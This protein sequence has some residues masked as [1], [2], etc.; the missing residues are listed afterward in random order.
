M[1]LSN[2][3]FTCTS[4][5]LICMFV[6]Y[7]M[8]VH[9]FYV[10]DLRVSGDSVDPSTAVHCECGVLYSLF[11]SLRNQSGKIQAIKYSILY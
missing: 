8:P 2:T 9:V 5:Q 11:W 10:S 1:F 6:K 4:E 7:D 3:R